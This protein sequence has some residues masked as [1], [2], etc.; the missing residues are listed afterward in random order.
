VRA[1]RRPNDLIILSVHWGENWGYQVPKEQQAFAHTFLD[2]AGGDIIYGHSSH[3]PK[4]I[5]VYRNKLIVY[6]CG[7]FLDDYEGITGHEEFRSHI[8]L[9]YFATVAPSTGHL[10]HLNLTPFVTRRFRL[11][12]GGSLEAEWI[13]D[14]LNREGKCFGTRAI[15]DAGNRL[16]LEW[17]N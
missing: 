7:D 4:A 17:Q 6:G 13:R 8:V 1:L 16:S 9:M 12:R 2:L 11:H 5:E 3:H 14:L 15:L 10:L